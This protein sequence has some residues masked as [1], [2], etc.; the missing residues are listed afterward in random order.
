MAQFK[1][2]QFR[3]IAWYNVALGVAAMVLQL[4]MFHGES[5]FKKVSKPRL[6]LFCSEDFKFNPSEF[7]ISLLNNY[8]DTFKAVCIM[9]RCACASEVNGSVCVS[10]CLCRLLQLLKD[11]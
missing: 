10:V 11:Q 5:S 2:D 8:A 6:S 9:P 1:V 3:S 4:A 7:L